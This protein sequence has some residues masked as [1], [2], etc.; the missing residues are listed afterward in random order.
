MFSNDILINVMRPGRYVGN[1][2][3]SAKKNFSKIKLSF[4]LCFPE[5]YEI[6]MSHLGIRILYDILNS[7][8]DMLCER[9]FC[10]WP[11]YKEV[12]INNS[13]ELC[14]LESRVPLRKFDILGFSI[15]NELNYTNI[16]SMLSLAGI[17]F[18]SKDRKDGFPLIIGGGNC[19]LNPEPIAEFFDLFVVGEAEEVISKIAKVCKAHKKKYTNLYSQKEELLINLCQIQGVY[20]PEFY[21]VEYNKD[22]TVKEFSV[23][24]KGAPRAIR[25]A[26]VKDIN[27]ALGCR[28]WIVPNIE[29][30]HDRIGIEIMRGCMHG[31]RFCQA[32]NYS[33]P[34]RLRSPRKILSL[35][36]KF[37]KI[38][39]YEQISLLSLSS[40]D[41]PQIKEIVKLL[42]EHFKKHAVSISLPSIRAK[43]VVGDISNLFSLQKK[44]GFTFAPEAG[45]EKLRTIINKNIKI[46]ELFQVA[47][48]AYKSG[49][50]RLKLYFMIG[51]PRE[52]YSDL[53]AIFD[54]AYRLSQKRREVCGKAAEINLSIANFI[55]KP[56]TPFQWLGMEKIGT[57]LEK[58]KYLRNIVGKE[59]RTLKLNFHDIYMS[60]LEMALSRGSRKLS[61]VILTA[62][63]NGAQFDQWKE[64]FNFNIWRNSFEENGLNLEEYTTQTFGLDKTL[65]WDFIDT[66]ISKQYLIDE[67]QKALT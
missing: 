54:L 6:G 49:Y 11:D 20:V 1:E 42:M 16:L 40:S 35:A 63:E 27:K 4:C 19:T 18:M 50:R 53:D 47:I 22:M 31:C 14:S 38:S 60:N 12:L 45:T 51:L 61:K 36:K 33:F 25:K 17:P 67:C 37:Y 26:Y 64:Y 41:H 2:W 58:Q 29:I 59:S 23:L 5:V 10:L 55:P 30:I 24:K 65:I 28:N 62:F 39:G 32:R 44:T 13:S 34:F 66:G 56:H 57:L 8:R 9:A 7:K 48:D 3:N 43:S 46:D 21:H 15:N 52:E